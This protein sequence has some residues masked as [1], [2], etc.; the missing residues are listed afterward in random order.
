MPKSRVKSAYMRAAQHAGKY[1][2]SLYDAIA[3]S[4][5]GQQ[6]VQGIALK[7]KAFQQ[8]IALGGQL[9]Q[10]GQSIKDKR[11]YNKEMETYVGEV[12]KQTGT[13]LIYERTSLL[14]VLSG[15]DDLK[16]LFEEKFR[17]GDEELTKG[18]IEARAMMSMHDE[19]YEY[20]GEASGWEYGT[21]TRGLAGSQRIGYK[22]GSLMDEETASAVGEKIYDKTGFSSWSTKLKVLG[23]IMESDANLKTEGFDRGRWFNPEE[24]DAYKQQKKIYESEGSTEKQKELAAEKLEDMYSL[25]NERMNWED[26]K[27]FIRKRESSTPYDVNKNLDKSGKITSYDIG[28]YQI[29]SRWVEEGEGSFQFTEEGG[30]YALYDDINKYLDEQVVNMAVVE[31]NYNFGKREGFYSPDMNEKN[32]LKRF[33]SAVKNIDWDDLVGKDSIFR[34]YRNQAPI[35]PFAGDDEHTKRFD[36]LSKAGLINEYWEIYN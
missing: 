14:D 12:E 3:S 13:P 23:D 16:N 7:D 5:E 34:K 36:S 6:Q 15:K 32:P 29:N 26:V 4:Y 19:D 18:Q 9:L 20:K 30:P 17:F 35:D 27:G 28:P 8:N 2:K 33:G 24:R 1:Q 10:L 22:Y 21:E 25:V 31:P 11:D